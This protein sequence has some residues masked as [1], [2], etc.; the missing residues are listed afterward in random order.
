MA[1]VS[2]QMPLKDEVR[3]DVFTIPACSKTVGAVMPEEAA[4][5]EFACGH[6]SKSVRLDTADT[7]CVVSGITSGGC[8]RCTRKRSM[9][10]KWTSTQHKMWQRLGVQ[11]EHDVWIQHSRND[12]SQ[13]LTTIATASTHAKS[14]T[15]VRSKRHCA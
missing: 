5:S 8:A 6:L 10:D 12:D 11:A 3:L 9:I 13:I 4:A 2:A 15:M 1:T 7:L 14:N